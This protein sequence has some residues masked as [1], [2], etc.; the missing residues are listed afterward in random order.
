MDVRTIVPLSLLM[1]A[2]GACEAAPIAGQAGV[3]PVAPLFGPIVASEVIS[4]RADEGDQVWLLVGGADLLH[5]DLAARSASRA[6]IK[7][8]AGEHCWGLARLQ[9]G[10]MWTLKGRNAVIR[11]DADGDVTREITLAE[12]HLGLF[13]AGDRL[14]YQQASFTPPGPALRAGRPGDSTTVAWSEM[15]TRTFDRIARASSVALNMVACGSGL[16]DE[17]PCWFPDE[18]AVSLISVAGA[19]RRLVLSGLDLVPPEI[20]LTAENPPRPVRDAYIDGEGG[21]WVLSSGTP[22]AVGFDRPGGWLL[23]R[24]GPRGEPIGVRR[25]AEPARLILRAGSGRA[26]LLT[27]GGMVAEAIP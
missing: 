20:L 9:D 1:A 27:S 8:G 19:T 12:P 22:S 16:R 11:I 3:I 21:I 13:A 2:L 24:Y 14:I 18:A 17:R 15:T 6:S 7:L 5:V 10:S 25:L 23:A 26:L 4:G